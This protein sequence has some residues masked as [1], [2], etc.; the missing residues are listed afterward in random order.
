MFRD[1]DVSIR[2]PPPPQQQ[3]GSPPLPE[4][5]FF[6]CITST[7]SLHDSDSVPFEV[8]PDFSPNDQR[9]PL[10]AHFL[11]TFSNPLHSTFPTLTEDQVSTC[12]RGIFDDLPSSLIICFSNP[13]LP[14][15]PKK[16]RRARIAT[17]VGEIEE[18]RSR[19][20]PD[21]DPEEF[22][23]DVYARAPF[24]PLPSAGILVESGESDSEEVSE[25][26]SY[27]E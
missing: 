3:D 9:H 13:P 16:N 12:L 15:H 10:F 20:I 19:S 4:P 21:E 14:A 24:H 17:L 25:T 6:H 18:G 23:P 22:C 7:V 8:I 1:S 27:E 2:P 11:E 5:I 26:S